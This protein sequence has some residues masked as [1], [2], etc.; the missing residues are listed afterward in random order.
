MKLNEQF[1]LQEI[2]GLWYLVPLGGEAFSGIVRTNETAAFVIERLRE[3]TSEAAL[4]DAMAA[5]Y[6]APREVLAADV[7]RVLDT[8]RSLNALDE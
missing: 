2:D 6:D 5:E 3:E 1:F 8:L 7:A 4:I